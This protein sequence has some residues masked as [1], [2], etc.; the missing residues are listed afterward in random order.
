MQTLD[1]LLRV[2]VRYMARHGL[3]RPYA[4]SFMSW[5]RNGFEVLRVQLRAF[6]KVLLID[7]VKPD[8]TE[9]VSIVCSRCNFG[10]QRP[11]FI[12]PKCRRRVAILY[13][14]PALLCRNCTGLHYKSQ[15][16]VRMMREFERAMRLQYKINSEFTRLFGELA[17]CD[18]IPK[19]K[20]RHWRTHDQL[21]MKLKAL[22]VGL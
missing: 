22:N 2:D 10:A 16:Q 11:W 9:R 12:C 4:S 13:L 8:A 15:H 1:D 7:G 3:L 6:S 17:P 5:S 14:C 19:K 18:E 21:V 20:Y